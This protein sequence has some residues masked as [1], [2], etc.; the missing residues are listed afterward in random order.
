MA[1]TNDVVTDVLGSDD[2]AHAQAQLELIGRLALGIDWD[3]FIAS[4]RRAD[5]VMPLLDPSLYR[6]AGGKMQ[7]VRELAEA[8]RSV[9]QVAKRHLEHS[10]GVHPN[11]PKAR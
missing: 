9:Q 5:V 10:S 3:A 7:Q 8:A 4:I 2:Y 6:R 11:P 1:A